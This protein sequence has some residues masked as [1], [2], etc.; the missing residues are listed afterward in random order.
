MSL[1]E[2]GRSKPIGGQ[3]AWGIGLAVLA[4][5]GLTILFSLLLEHQLRAQHGDAGGT[6]SPLAHRPPDRVAEQAAIRGSVRAGQKAAARE[7]GQAALLVVDV[8]H[9][10]RCNDRYGHAVGDMVLKGIAKCLMASVNR[11]QDLA[12]RVGGEEFA[13]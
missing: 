9:F 6:R 5:C 7:S 3:K 10:K 2:L 4:L 11:P 13:V 1:S 12:A 8:D